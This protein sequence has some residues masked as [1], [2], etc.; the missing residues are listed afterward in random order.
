MWRL[1]PHLAGIDRIPDWFHGRVPGPCIE[2]DVTHE[3]DL[4]ADDPLGRPAARRAR[5]AARTAER[6]G[7]SVAR[8]GNRGDWNAYVTLYR[9]TVTRWGERRSIV[10][11]DAL[12]DALADA[13]RDPETGIELWLARRE[14]RPVA[15]AIVV[16]GGERCVYWHGAA[17]AEG[18]SDRAPALLMRELIE[19]ARGR[20]EQV[21]DFNPSGGHEGVEAFKAGFGAAARATPILRRVPRWQRAVRR[22]RQQARRPSE[23]AR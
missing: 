3:V 1:A 2:H 23:V 16:R 22:F 11:P 5:R 17:D 18:L 8:A 13:A 19:D 10:H 9:S 12:F 20:G 7:V 4:G 6:R 15:G 21:F 14:A